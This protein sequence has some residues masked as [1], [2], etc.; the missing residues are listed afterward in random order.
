MNGK[1]LVI[2]MTVAL[3]A[4]HSTLHADFNGKER[5]FRDKQVNYYENLVEY[6]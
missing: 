6:H 2:L 4:S 5:D 1:S 3:L